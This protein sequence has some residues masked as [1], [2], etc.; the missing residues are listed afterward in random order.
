MWKYTPAL[1]KSGIDHLIS[2]TDIFNA[3]KEV[4]D[5]QEETKATK[6]TA[7]ALRV[8]RGSPPP[9][10]AKDENL[11]D[12]VPTDT[13]DDN[14]KKETPARNTR[15]QS[16]SLSIMDKVMLSCCQM[17]CTSY[18]IDPQK[19]SSRKYP[20]QLFCELAG[21]V[22]DEEKGDLLEYCH[23]VKHSN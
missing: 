22:L 17:F 1:V 23:V 12:L 10:V 14:D 16:T 3:T 7:H 4:Y 2:L 6:T 9:R 18:Q 15:Y 5:D 11:P 13:I 21:A 8:P 19:V 20:L